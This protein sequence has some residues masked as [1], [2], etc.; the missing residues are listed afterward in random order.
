MG[1]STALAGRS[2]LDFARDVE[3]FADALGLARFGL[4][5]VSAGGPYAL[6][7]ARGLPDR[8]L[9]TALC[10]SL[11]PSCSLS[12]SAETWPLRLG[13]WWLSRAPRVCRAAGDSLLPVLARHPRLLTCVI[14]ANA[15]PSDRRRLGQPAE[16]TA[17]ARAFW[18]RP[19]QAW[20]E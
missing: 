12:R 9:R 20:R 2:V 3:E 18:T 17:R 6:A 19:S 14:A 5:G 15:S 10:S 4:V 7:T 13:L 8:V 11:A 1:G 16:R